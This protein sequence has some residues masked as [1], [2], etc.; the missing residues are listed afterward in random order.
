MLSPPSDDTL[1]LRTAARAAVD[2]AAEAACRAAARASGLV[3]D[4]R[5]RSRAFDAF[6]ARVEA[7]QTEVSALAAALENAPEHLPGG[8][9]FWPWREP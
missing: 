6:R 8:P 4:V 7:W 3:A 5:W 9:Q 2:A 1:M